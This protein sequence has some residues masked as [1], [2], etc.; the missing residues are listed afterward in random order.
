MRTLQ[1]D[2]LAV[3]SV[4]EI[5]EPPNEDKMQPITSKLRERS[6]N[7]IGTAAHSEL[8][9]SFKSDQAS[10]R[11]LV[12]L[13]LAVTHLIERCLVVVLALACVASVAEGLGPVTK[14]AIRMF[15]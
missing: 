1:A 3:P 15:W 13:L 12:L 4:G 8:I 10:T 14:A 9:R 6:S 5:I 2:I 7:T 11:L